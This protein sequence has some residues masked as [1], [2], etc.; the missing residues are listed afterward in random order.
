MRLAYVQLA[1]ALFQ[2][3]L[4]V[5]HE[6]ETRPEYEKEHRLC[7]GRIR[8]QKLHNYGTAGG[9]FTEHMPAIIRGSGLVTLGSAIAFLRVLQ[10]EGHTVRKLGFSFLLGG[11]LSNLYDRCR[12]GYVVDY[13]SFRTPFRRL[14]SLVFNLSDFFIFAGAFLV[15]LG[16]T[17][18]TQE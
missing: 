7:N 18:H 9:K 15:C 1:L 3:D 2:T 13:V 10:K 11:A 6:I 8:V 17:D 4:A 16:Q 5:K 14:S 12:K